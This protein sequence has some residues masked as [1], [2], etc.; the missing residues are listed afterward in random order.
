M[1]KVRFD[2][3]GDVGIVTLADPPLNLFGRE[4]VGD[5][6]TVLDEA[7]GSG[8]R[9]LVVRAEG[10]VFTGGADVKMFQGL[11]A[12]QMGGELDLIAIP[13][14]LEAMPIPTLAVVHALCLTAGFELALGCDLIWAAES[15]QF[16]LVEAV[17]GVTPFMGGTQRVAER[18]GPARARELVMTGG[19][20]PAPKLVDWGVVNRA[21]ADDELEEKAMRFAARLAAGPTRAHAATKRIVRTYLDEGVAGADAALAQIAGEVVETEDFRHGVRSFLEQGPGNATFAGR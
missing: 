11:T 4:M 5:L 7:A 3:D 21:V 12:E 17:V 8:A 9:A 10:T 18:A 2:R 1:A 20:Y 13:R 14:K 6:N 15:A 16:G 19:L